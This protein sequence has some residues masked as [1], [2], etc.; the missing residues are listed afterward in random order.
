MLIAYGF[1]A[2][3]DLYSLHSLLQK[4][5]GLTKQ[6]HRRRAQLKRRCPVNWLPSPRASRCQLAWWQRATGIAMVPA[7]SCATSSSTWLGGATIVGDVGRSYATPV[8]PSSSPSKHAYIREWIRCCCKHERKG[9]APLY[10]PPNSARR[11]SGFAN[12]VLRT[13]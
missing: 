2:T 12:I 3:S 7:A 11:T 9:P 13:I 6:S 8:L 5:D 1:H 10:L 4:Y